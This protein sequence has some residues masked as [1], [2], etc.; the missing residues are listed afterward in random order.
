MNAEAVI[1]RK[2]DT[3]TTNDIQLDPTESKANAIAVYGLKSASFAIPD[4]DPDI[5]QYSNVHEL[6]VIIILLG[7]SYIGFRL[8]SAKHVMKSNPRKAKY[9]TEAPY[10]VPDHPPFSSNTNGV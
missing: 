9:I 10:I 4:I 7:K 8:S 5:K 1:P 6:I 2:A 3:Y